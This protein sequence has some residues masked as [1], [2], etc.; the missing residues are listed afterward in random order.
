MTRVAKRTLVSI[1]VSAAILAVSVMFL[2]HTKGAAAMQPKIENQ[3]AFTMIGIAARTS[4][5]KENTADAIIGKQWG[6]LMRESLLESIPNKADANI[7]AVYTD[8]A[9]DKDGEYTFVL[10]ARVTHAENV[11]AGMVAKIVP[12]GKY[13][14]FTSERG[15]VPEV[16]ISTWKR[17]WTTPKD[18]PGGN[19]AYKAD[20]ELYGQGAQNPADTV[21][22]IHIGIK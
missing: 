17:I 5:A 18:A 21:M 2:A 7:V 14:V 22:E 8:Y 19:R 11:P 13:A 3:A 1:G 12:A 20:F 4:N 16:V 6:R 10:G 15:S 9:S